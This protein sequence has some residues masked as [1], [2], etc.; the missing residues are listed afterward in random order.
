MND[1]PEV[2]VT[3]RRL[4]EQIAWY[5]G[6]SAWHQRWYKTLKTL[7]I[8]A[9]AVIP[10][11]SLVVPARSDLALVTTGLGSLIVVLEGVQ[12][13]NQFHHHWVTYRSTCEQLKHEK[14]LWTAKAGPYSVDSDRLLAERI[15]A[16]ISREHSLWVSTQEQAKQKLDKS[17]ETRLTT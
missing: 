6:K 8:V 13:L 2:T 1:R 14:Y 17:R 15:E 9:A 7:Q 12:S 10:I 16:L 5:G 3:L 4:D 11:A